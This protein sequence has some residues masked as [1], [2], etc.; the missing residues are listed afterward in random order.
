M[1]DSEM[2][3]TIE[4]D[5]QDRPWLGVAVILNFLN[6]GDLA[7]GRPKLVTR[8]GAAIDAANIDWLQ[9]DADMIAPFVRKI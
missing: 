7:C 1:L 6:A 8:P 2:A 4:S 5:R 3:F 9:I